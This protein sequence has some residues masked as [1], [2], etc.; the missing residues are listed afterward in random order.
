MCYSSRRKNNAQ[1]NYTEMLFKHTART[2]S[3]PLPSNVE[4]R[5]EKH[6][7]SYQYSWI[8]NSL[9]QSSSVPN[10]FLCLPTISI[11]CKHAHSRHT[12]GQPPHRVDCIFENCVANAMCHSNCVSPFIR[13]ACCRLLFTCDRVAMRNRGVVHDVRWAVVIEYGCLHF[14]ARTTLNITRERET[15]R[16]SGPA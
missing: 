1:V 7:K 5:K 10:H 13:R 4:T 2:E 15:S 6:K 12:Q 11:E 3:Q 8:K 14:R 16:T 9:I